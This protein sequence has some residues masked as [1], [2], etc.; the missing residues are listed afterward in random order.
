MQGGAERMKNPEVWAH[1]SK[2]TMYTPLAPEHIE[3]MCG[4]NCRIGKRLLE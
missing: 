2:S 1:M 4:W 3:G